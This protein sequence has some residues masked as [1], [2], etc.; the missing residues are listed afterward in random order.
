MENELVVIPPKVLYRYENHYE[1]VVLYSF[2]ILKE[3]PRGVWIGH[4]GKQKFVLAGNDGKRFG[5]S[6]REAALTSFRKRKTRQIGF[7]S[8][9]LDN[10]KFALT[11]VAGLTPQEIE[12]VEGFLNM[13]K[14]NYFYEK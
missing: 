8:V 10:V 1:K 11:S 6:T 3:T 2:P 7:L 9:Q 5:Y 14:G 13:A 4:Y 12:K